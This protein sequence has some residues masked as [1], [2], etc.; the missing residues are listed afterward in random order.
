MSLRKQLL[1][2][3]WC[4]GIPSF[5]GI[6]LLIII[7]LVICKYLIE[8]CAESC[9]YQKEERKNDIFTSLK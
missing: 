6:Q 3:K 9:Q 7:N 5:L 2:V 8:D 4:Y 1:A